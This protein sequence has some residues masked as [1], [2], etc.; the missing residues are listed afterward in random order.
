MNFHENSSIYNS[1]TINQPLLRCHIPDLLQETIVSVRD[2]HYE[3]L[4]ESE[5]DGTVTLE[6]ALDR[7]LS[8][9]QSS[10]QLLTQLRYVWMALTLAIV[11]EPTIKYYQPDSSIP[12][13][14][15]NQLTDWLLKA[16]A[17]LSEPG[18][19]LN[20]NFENIT[21]IISVDADRLSSEKEIS[22]F[23]VLSE[24]LDVYSNALK[25]LEPNYSLPALLE[26]LEDC[27]E[28][29]AI[30]PGSDGRRELFNWWLLD[31]VPSCWCLRPPT[32]A[33]SLNQV[34]NIHNNPAFSR[35]EKISNLIWSYIFI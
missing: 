27:L 19:R 11:V 17:E 33:N 1:A 34:A 16:L 18:N 6:N 24:A 14:T 5:L 2:N 13:K 7:G 30:F 23:Q 25:T 12:E 20:G 15:I 35:L 26:I 8:L 4:Y 9:F 29:Y 31:V 22:S 3:E 21:N 32:A 28:G 10:N